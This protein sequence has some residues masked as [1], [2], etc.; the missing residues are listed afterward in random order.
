MT[1]L[2]NITP[3][4][5]PYQVLSSNSAGDGSWHAI[6][7]TEKGLDFCREN[8]GDD[9]KTYEDAETWAIDH[10][11]KVADSYSRQHVNSFRL[12]RW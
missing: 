8:A 9:I 12:E 11:S 1:H 6:Y 7:M 4:C 3:S 10:F 2:T 5:D